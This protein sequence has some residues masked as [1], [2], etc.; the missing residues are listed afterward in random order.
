MTKQTKK[1]SKKHHI[2]LQLCEM[3]LCWKNALGILLPFFPLPVLWI[4]Q[5]GKLL[6]FKEA[7]SIKCV[8]KA[9]PRKRQT[10]ELQIKLKT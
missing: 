3:T 2:K 10:S 8:A 4:Q 5:S 1:K 7:A 6:S 9:R